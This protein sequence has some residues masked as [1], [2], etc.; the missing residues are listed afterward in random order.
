MKI[1]ILDNSKVIV[2]MFQSVLIQELNFDLKITTANSLEELKKYLQNSSFFMAVTN[3][4]LSDTSKNE[5]LELLYSY[6]I[7]TI[8]FSSQIEYKLLQKE[9]Y[10]NIIDY[11]FKDTNGFKY[12]ARLIEATGYCSH[13]K[14]L[15]VEDSKVAQNIL[16]NMLQKLFLTVFTAQDGFEALEILK[17]QDDFSALIVDYVMPH[18]NGLEFLKKYKSDFQ[19]SSIPIFVA[20]ANQD[21]NIK[22]E[23]YKNGVFDLIQKP[24]LE[25]ELKHKLINLF[26]DTKHYEENLT[27]RKMIEEYI[28]TSTTNEKGN[29]TSVSEAF[30]QIS[31]YSK[32]ELLG[33]NHK[34][35]RQ[36]DMKDSLYQ[37]MWNT[38]TSGKMWRGEIKNRKKDG[39]Y[40]W[41]DAIIEPLFD[42]DKK[43]KGYYAIRI[44]ITNKKEIERISITDG[45]TDIFNRRH[46]NETFPK[47]INS[48][49][50]NDELV[51][52]LLMDI[53]HF[54]QYNDNY[55]HQR[56][57]DVL[58]EFA[59]T[60]KETLQRADDLAFR[61]GGEE[62]GLVYKAESKEKALEFANQV[63]Q[64]IE[65]MKIAHEYSS[66]S[67][68]VTA[69]MG[70]VC[71]YASKIGD[72]DTVYK[73]ADDLL[74][75][76]KESG[77]NRVSTAKEIA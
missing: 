25:E 29:I 32:K 46:F 17:H 7:P 15:V 20:T 72:M 1:I 68:Y 11:V 49:K 16:K 73:Q 69:S 50:R 70:L 77:R 6:D 54:K 31:G 8:I 10:P 3:L 36:P 28:I 65:N 66:A 14:V 23:F 12:I 63:R 5:H 33:Q 71:E 59:K 57:D 76:S 21:E 61:L 52:F 45:L 40:Y 19:Y 24:V 47:V 27:K 2:S 22:R 55:G 38:I 51:C 26:L 60:L 62:F 30:C 43:I 9:K 42:N 58:I 74:Y 75:E 64:K 41:V 35:L 13:K 56:G 39:G 18:M 34:I 37:D 67:S 4:I 48:A 53:D 44:D